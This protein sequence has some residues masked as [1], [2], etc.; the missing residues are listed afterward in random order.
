MKTLRRVCSVLI[1]G[2]SV[3]FIAACSTAP[4]SQTEFMRKMGVEDVTTREL[5]LMVYAFGTQFGGS[6]ELAAN[7][8]Q[9]NSNSPDIKRNAILWKVNGI[10]LIHRA[11]FSPD[12]LGGLSGTWALCVQMREFFDTGAGKDVFGQWQYIA[13][14]AVRSLETQAQDMAAAVIGE[15]QLATFQRGLESWALENSFENMLFVRVG[16]SSEFLRGLAGDT[17]GGLAAAA[18]MNVVMQ[19]INDRMAILSAYI[20]RHVQWQTELLMA[21][22]PE[23]IAGQS[24]SIMAVVESNVAG[25]LEPLLAFWIQEREIMTAYLSSERSAVLEGIAAE[26]LAALR[27]LA[28]ERNVI[29]ERITQE[30]NLTIEQINALTLT[31]MENMLAESKELSTSTIDHVFWRTIQLMALPAVVLLVVCVAV[32]LWIRNSINRYLRL[33]EERTRGAAG[34]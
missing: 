10:P 6:V 27:A 11:M 8:I 33:L 4:P 26:R 24:D 5:Q 17:A 29:L 22:A 30:R 9:Q 31:A 34:R 1:L 13:V 18:S 32:L 14:D 16:D 12:P 20:P 2:S 3:M 28:D 15:S 21:Q 19:T 7:K 23:L 25:M